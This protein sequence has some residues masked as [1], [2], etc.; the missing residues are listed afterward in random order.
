MESRSGA[1]SVC[2]QQIEIKGVS[3][4][5]PAWL[6]RIWTHY[7]KV[8][9][10]VVD[11]GLWIAEYPDLL[12]RIKNYPGIEAY[13]NK[14]CSLPGTEIPASCDITIKPRTLEALRALTTVK[15]TKTHRRQATVNG[16]EIDM[17]SEW[18]LAL[19]RGDIPSLCGAA[20][21]LLNDL[22]EAEDPR[23][24]KKIRIK[25]THLIGCYGSAIKTEDPGLYERIVAPQLSWRESE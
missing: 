24:R 8:K 3:D 4:Q 19:A 22:G 12:E 14:G 25:L 7:G 5:L 1:C 18:G 9:E 15:P 16:H 11:M 2:S 20:R 13:P 21:M 6:V 23:T 10:I 17:R